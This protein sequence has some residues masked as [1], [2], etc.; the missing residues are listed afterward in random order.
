LDI[1]KKVLLGLGS[2]AQDSIETTYLHSNMYK[3]AEQARK[4]DEIR[5]QQKPD[6]KYD[7]FLAHL[8]RFLMAGPATIINDLQDDSKKNDIE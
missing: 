4:N 6:E 8:G 1:A 7:S 2:V 5:A 3:L